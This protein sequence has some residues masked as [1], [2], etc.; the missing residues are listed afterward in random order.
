[1]P[2]VDNFA[3]EPDDNIHGEKFAQALSQGNY[4]YTEY[5]GNNNYQTFISIPFA[6][7]IWGIDICKEKIKLVGPDGFLSSKV[8]QPLCC[9][10]PSNIECPVEEG[11]VAIQFTVK[12]TTNNTYSFAITFDAANCNTTDP[13]KFILRFR[14]AQNNP[15]TLQELENSII[16]QIPAQK[17]GI[18]IQ[19][20]GPGKFLI[21]L[22]QA[23][24]LYNYKWNETLD[25]INFCN[26]KPIPCNVSGITLELESNLLCCS[27]SITNDCG[28][29]PNFVRFA[30]TI[31]PDNFNTVYNPPAL[32][33]P[34]DGV[35]VHIESITTPPGFSPYAT[36][37]QKMEASLNHMD[38]FVKPGMDYAAY[39]DYVESR[40]QHLFS[41]SAAGKGF[42]RRVGNRFDIFVDKD[43]FTFAVTPI[44]TPLELR[45]C[46]E[47]IRIFQ[48]YSNNVQLPLTKQLELKFESKLGQTSELSE[49][50]K[51]LN[52]EKSGFS[53]PVQ[54]KG[55]SGGNICCPPNI[56]LPKCCPC[57]ENTLC[58]IIGNLSSSLQDYV[59]SLRLQN[60]QSVLDVYPK[61]TGERLLALLKQKFSVLANIEYENE[62]YFLTVL[63]TEYKNQQ[64]P[65]KDAV[66]IEICLFPKLNCNYSYISALYIQKINNAIHT[67]ATISK[68]T[69]KGVI[70]PKRKHQFINNNWIR[71]N[72]YE[73]SPAICPKDS[74]CVEDRDEFIEDCKDCHPSCLFT[75]KLYFQFQMPDPYNKW[76]DDASIPLVKLNC[77]D[78]SYCWVDRETAL[79]K[80]AKWLATVEVISKSKIIDIPFD[81]FVENSFVGYL[82]KGRFVQQITI[83]PKNL[84]ESF[85]LRFRFNTLDG[86]V[87]FY[88][89]PYMRVDCEDTIVLEGI[90]PDYGAAAQDCIGNTYEIPR[91]YIGN[92]YKHKLK[93]R[94][95]GK[96]TYDAFEINTTTTNKRVIKVD[97]KA[98]Y[99]VRTFP[100]P[101]YLAEQVKA[102]LESQMILI[103]GEEYTFD[104]SVSRSNNDGSMWIM[105]FNVTKVARSCSQINFSCLA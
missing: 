69:T 38:L 21:L 64:D 89:E 22:S 46:N 37:K 76:E 1:M 31:E 44:D 104:G 62:C 93:V 100:I 34:I 28:A 29:L 49:R 74:E 19:R 8:A 3:N 9:E 43:A 105:D 13:E 60:N 71:P 72:G 48:L 52:L 102:I 75:D 2:I 25:T 55:L 47:R 53:F 95:P 85:Y 41:T 7:R 16:Q 6:Q 61:M 15:F 14:G 67:T 40:W 101:P 50:N 5:L 58:T 45:G 78:E 79:K 86:I 30:Y 97:T 87:S 24:L 92:V 23:F 56:E 12:P 65:N 36:T 10:Y 84:P 63:T 81:S 99:K 103:N 66:L 27:Q 54:Y 83:N 20:E 90:Y 59:M 35:H 42:V 77:D 18:K 57:S 94:I 17:K 98:N 4:I 73:E 26:F 88:T 82:G 80:D 33:I 70:S 39:L 51:T 91:Q 96:I 68:S 32:S 11:Y